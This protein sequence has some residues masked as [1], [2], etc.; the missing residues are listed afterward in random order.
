MQT[1]DVLSAPQ[2]AAAAP[3]ETKNTAAADAASSFA[4]VLGTLRE[5]A[6][7]RAA[8][9]LKDAAPHA[10]EA[11][12]AK[13]REEMAT[14]TVRRLLPD[15][16]IRITEYQGSKIKSVLYRHPEMIAVPDLS[17][18]AWHNAS[19]GTPAAQKKMKLI[20]HRCILD[21]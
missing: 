2:T 5:E 18:P 14:E 12:A 6:R 8:G 1:Q 7:T 3:A 17:D 20:P 19:D 15:G 16:T 13:L 10:Q 4:S 11:S 21:E 9:I